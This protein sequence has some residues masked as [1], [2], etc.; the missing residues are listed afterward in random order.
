MDRELARGRGEYNRG[1]YY[2]ALGC[3]GDIPRVH[4]GPWDRLWG[5]GYGCRMA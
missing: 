5:S 1:C 4:G 2:R 3:V